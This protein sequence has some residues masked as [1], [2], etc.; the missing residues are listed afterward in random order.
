[1]DTRHAHALAQVYDNLASIPQ[2]KRGRVWCT[3]CGHTET[4]NGAGAIMGGGWPKHCGY[5]MTID[6]PEE[7]AALANGSDNPSRTGDD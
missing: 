1:M 6:S 3:V 2:I 7:R 5:T 4:V